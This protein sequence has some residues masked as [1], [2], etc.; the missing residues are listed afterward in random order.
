MRARPLELVLPAERVEVAVIGLEHVL[1]DGEQR[2][3]ASARTLRQPSATGAFDGVVERAPAGLEDRPQA[4]QLSGIDSAVVG[5][6]LHTRRAEVR[7]RV[8]AQ[9]LDD[10]EGPDVR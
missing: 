2:T 5:F 4:S 8:A 7:R 3:T 10:V 6:G 1:H 9:A